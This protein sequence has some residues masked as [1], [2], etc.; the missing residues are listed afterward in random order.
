MEQN[1]CKFGWGKEG[2]HVVYIKHWCKSERCGKR[3]FLPGSKAF[4]FVLKIYVQTPGLELLVAHIFLCWGCTEHFTRGIQFSKMKSW[5]HCNSLPCCT[6]SE[7]PSSPFGALVWFLFPH[8]WLV[9]DL[10]G[11]RACTDV[12]ADALAT[13]ALQSEQQ[14]QKDNQHLTV[15]EASKHPARYPSPFSSYMGW[16]GLFSMSVWPESIFWNFLSKR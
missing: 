7:Q 10:P 15:G 12:Q 11:I 2:T 6:G 14:Q 13:K 4:V 8:M 3:D 5:C 1:H 16:F 9:Q